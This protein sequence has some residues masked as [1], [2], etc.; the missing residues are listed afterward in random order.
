MRHLK[1]NND[2]NKDISNNN[3]NKSKKENRYKIINSQ[4]NIPKIDNKEK[5]KVKEKEVKKKIIKQSYKYNE[6]NSPKKKEKEEILEISTVNDL[7]IESYENKYSMINSNEENEKLRRERELEMQRKEELKIVEK[8]RAEKRNLQSMMKK[9]Q[10]EFDSNR[11]T[12]D[13]NGKV[14]NLKFQN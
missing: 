4:K 9:M 5:I 10:R 7:P 3:E 8:E 11:L 2:E 1:N 14:I 6:D 13:P 12:F